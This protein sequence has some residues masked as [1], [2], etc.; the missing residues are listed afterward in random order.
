L[1]FHSASAK[2]AARH[3]V[4]MECKTLG[5]DTNVLQQPES[6]NDMGFTD[7]SLSLMYLKRQ[8][9]HHNPTD[10]TRSRH[11]RRKG[12]TQQVRRR[13]ETMDVQS[14]TWEQ[15]T[16]TLSTFPI[17]VVLHAADGYY[18]TPIEQTLKMQQ[19]KNKWKIAI[20]VHQIREY[21]FREKTIASS[22]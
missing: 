4:L 11:S 21:V 16:N 9:P 20:D 5:E 3:Q 1:D 14:Q 19:S 18:P 13:N 6:D 8:S 2:N 10:H 22:K 15:S 17:Q 12:T 7:D